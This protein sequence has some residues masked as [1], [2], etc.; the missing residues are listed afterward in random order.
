MAVPIVYIPHG[1]GPMPLLGEPNH[2][3]LTKML[4]GLKAELGSPQAILII[5]AHWE[6]SV[7]TVS[8]GRKPSIIFDYYGFPEEAY[9]ITYPAPGDPKLAKRVAE[10]LETQGIETKL[11]ASRGYD[12]GTFVPLILMYPEANIPIV[13]LS[14]VNNLDP[15]VQ[16]NLG[17][18]IAQLANEDVLIVGSGMSFHNMSAFRNNN[19]SINSKSLEFDHW[20]NETLLSES[21]SN[22][23][24]EIAIIDWASSPQA[25][26]C[27]PREEHLLPLHVCF[28]AAQQLNLNAKNIF[29]ESLLGAKISGFLWC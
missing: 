10:L 21:L 17:K 3:P 16:Y 1:G 2:L 28:G 20:L 11:D 5:S 8:S 26:Y 23:E 9:Q 6:E 27:H 13:Q 22:L 4:R 18:A 12:H 25:R 15:R 29:D 24:K 14:L 7:A 19:D